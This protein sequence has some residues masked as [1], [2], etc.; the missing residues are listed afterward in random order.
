MRQLALSCTGHQRG[1]DD[2]DHHMTGFHQVLRQ[3]IHMSSNLTGHGDMAYLALEPVFFTDQ[4]CD[5]FVVDLSRPQGINEINDGQASGY[6]RIVQARNG[7]ALVSIL[8]GIIDPVRN[9]LVLN[10]LVRL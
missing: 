7:A 3:G 1:R 9:G 6:L 4:V 10:G 5:Y 2:S 8:Q